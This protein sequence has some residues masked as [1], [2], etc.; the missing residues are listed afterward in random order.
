MAYD[1]CH[2]SEGINC[3]VVEIGDIFDVLKKKGECKSLNFFLNIL[4]S[5]RSYRYIYNI[6]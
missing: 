6:S 4:E 1:V 2:S 3:R 5:I